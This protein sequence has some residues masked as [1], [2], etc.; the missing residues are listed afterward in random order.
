MSEKNYPEGWTRYVAL[1]NS[2][3]QAIPKELA[4]WAARFRAAKSF[5]GISLE[6]MSDDAEKGYFVGLKLTLVDTALEAFERAI[7]LPPG[8]LG[9]ADP[10]IGYDFWESRE[11]ELRAAVSAL[12]NKSMRNEI[13]EFLSSDAD[14]CQESDLRV[15]LRAFRHLTAHGNFNPSSAGVYTSVSYRELLLRLADCALEVCESAFQDEF[16]DADGDV[17]EEIIVTV[18]S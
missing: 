15:I 17:D 11:G 2:A 7:G 6:G 5:R 16:L 3:D 1:M 9:F 10:D 14:S 18:N 13:E 8:D 4:V 12:E